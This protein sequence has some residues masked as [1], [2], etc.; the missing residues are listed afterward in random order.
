MAEL[1]SIDP[2]TL[3]ANPNNPRRTPASPAMDEQLL[4]SIKAVGIIQPRNCATA[5]PLAF[6]MQGNAE[7]ARQSEAFGRRGALP[8]RFRQ[9]DCQAV[10]PDFSQFLLPLQRRKCGA[11]HEVRYR[12]L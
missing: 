6:R 9:G 8:R 10:G 5:R 4:A 2:R 11:F 3:H 12:D 1:R 7:I